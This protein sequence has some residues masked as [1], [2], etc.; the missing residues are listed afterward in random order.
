MIFYNF[1]VA[2]LKLKVMKRLFYSL[3]GLLIISAS[4]ISC[5]NVL[6]EGVKSGP[7]FTIYGRW[8]GISCADV[9]YDISVVNKNGGLIKTYKV[10]GEVGEPFNLDE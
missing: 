7:Q 6:V 5:S 4:F 3:F 1:V 10:K 8:N 9:D 2:H